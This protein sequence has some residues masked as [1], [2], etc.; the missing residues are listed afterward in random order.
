MNLNIF[1][2]SISSVQS[3]NQL[4]YYALIA[5]SMLSLILGVAAV[6]KD[7]V[8]T[9]IPPTLHKEADIGADFASTSY[10]EAWALHLSLSLGN[11]T[12]T[13]VGFVKQTV[14]PLLSP[15]VYQDVVSALEKQV[16]EIKSNHVTLYFEPR[17][18]LRE[19]SSGKI[20]VHGQSVMETPTGQRE[21]TER[22]YEFIIGV[23]NYMPNL[24]YIDTY[25]GPPRTT[26]ELDRLK[27]ME[28]AARKRGN[29]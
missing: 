5:L 7:A 11:V 2:D 19:E 20:F 17:R 13:T 22:S 15:I 21:R 25:P 1:K 4:Q 3:K 26:D 29:S 27:R 9:V 23:L 6:S 18:V 8:V 12:P 10:L 28:D 24:T 14:E 16:D